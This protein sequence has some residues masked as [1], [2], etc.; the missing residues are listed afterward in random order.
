MNRIVILAVVGTAAVVAA[1]AAQLA[2]VPIAM[3]GLAAW[4]AWGR[5]LQPIA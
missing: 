5:P 1:F 3:L 4:F 2:L